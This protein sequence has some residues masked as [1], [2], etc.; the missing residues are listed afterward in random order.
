MKKER[1]CSKMRNNVERKS[2]NKRVSRIREKV[3]RGG[4]AREKM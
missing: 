3:E 2:R 1:E 4:E